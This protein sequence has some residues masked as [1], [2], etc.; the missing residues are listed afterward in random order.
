MR[1]EFEVSVKITD[2]CPD[3]N[4]LTEYEGTVNGITYDE[5]TSRWLFFM[6]TGK[7]G[8]REQYNNLM[9]AYS[10]MEKLN[11][12]LHEN[13]RELDEVN[14]ELSEAKDCITMLKKRLYESERTVAKM[15]ED[16]N[17]K[18]NWKKC[19]DDLINEWADFAEKEQSLRDICDENLTNIMK[20]HGVIDHN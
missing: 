16:L 11:D 19:S 5:D 3:Y 4:S 2:L 6:L 12:K 7:N 9:A 14:N 18:I 13:M 1:V 10:H 17:A 15:K 8:A 20:K